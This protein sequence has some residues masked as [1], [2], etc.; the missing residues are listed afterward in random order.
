MC[1]LYGKCQSCQNIAGSQVGATQWNYNSS[2]LTAGQMEN[3]AKATD[4]SNSDMD[5]SDDGQ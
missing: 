2:K 5:W 1:Q 4:F 3:I